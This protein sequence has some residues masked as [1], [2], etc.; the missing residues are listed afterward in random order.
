MPYYLKAN[1]HVPAAP[2]GNKAMVFVVWNVPAANWTEN[3]GSP[4]IFQQYWNWMGLNLYNGADTEMV[5][6]IATAMFIINTRYELTIYILD[7][8]LMISM[9]AIGAIYNVKDT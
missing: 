4:R 7:F 5:G 6:A 1:P 2:L 3:N 8:L 9:V